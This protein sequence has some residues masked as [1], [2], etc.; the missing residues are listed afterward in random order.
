MAIKLFPSL[1]SADFGKLQ[2]EIDRAE[3]C[4][5]G[6]HF[7]V[8][9]GHFVPN[10]TVGA[11]VLSCLHSNKPFDAHLMVTN[12]E[13][14]LDDF[15]KAGAG[16]ISIHKE[17]TND[18]PGLLSKIQDAGVKAGIVFNP[19]TEVDLSLVDLTDFV[20]VMGVYPGF[21]GQKF[22][23]EVLNKLRLVRE[24]FPQ[25]E[26]QIDGGINQTTISSALGAGANS[27]VSGS[28]FWQSTDLKQAAE[29]LTGAAD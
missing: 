6:F 24:K 17:T 5:S 3:G 27:V 16:L 25:K 20:L 26:L 18:A 23:P 1:L 22:I 28:F 4:V 9:D 12:P 13:A 14:L 11:P 8:M 21:S 15:I 19:D 29:I 2:A 7:D 10:L